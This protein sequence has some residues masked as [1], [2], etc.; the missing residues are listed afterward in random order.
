[1]IAQHSIYCGMRK[2]L[3][4]QASMYADHY[5]YWKDDGKV[6][7][8]SVPE[9]QRWR[10]NCTDCVRTRE[11][12]EV[13]AEII[14]AYKLEAVD[15]FQQKMFWPVLQCMQRGVRI[16]KKRRAEMAEELTTEIDSRE[17]FFRRVLGHPLNPRSS[18]QMQKLFYDDL[19]QKKNW[20][21][22]KGMPATLTCD[23]KALEKIANEEP[24]LRGFIKKIQEYRSLG[25]FLSTFVLAPLDIDGRMRTSY[26]I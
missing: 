18:P 2:S 5:V 4:F 11:V 14:K 8:F 26:N 15:A 6:V 21:K 12:G 10:Y 24:I 16:D 25:V 9:H 3:D 20:A 22:R 17:A 7:D 23:D 13:E 1:M 19:G